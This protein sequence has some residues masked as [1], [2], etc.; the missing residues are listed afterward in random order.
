MKICLDN[1]IFSKVKNGGV[2]NYWFELIEYLEKQNQDEL[3]YFESINAIE[4]F[5]RKKL[6]LSS[7][8][9]KEVKSDSI[10]RFMPISY[11]SDEKLIFHSSY[12]RGLNGC[13]NKI[14]VTTVYDFIHSYYSSFPKKQLHNFLKFN[15]IKRS[16]GII[17]IS[18][19]TYNDLNK[20]YALKKNQKATVIHVGVSD[21]YFPIKEYT[22]KEQQFITDK[23]L[24]D[25]FILFVGGRTGYKNFDFVVSVLNDNPQLKLVIVGGGE[26][27]EEEKK[28]FSNTA[29]MRVTHFK[30][31]ENF[32]L[33]VL[34]N[35]SKALVYPS[36]YEGF[37]I[38]VVEAM[39]AGCPVIGLNNATIREVA[40]NSAVLLDTLSVSEFNAKFSNLNHSDFRSS[41]IEMGLEAS[42]NYSWKKCSRETREFYGS[43]ESLG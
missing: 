26:I 4:N 7:Q 33:N 12:Y 27:T 32:E 41:A 31:A 17:C 36:S 39:R 3:T 14:E 16:N 1:I 5:H 23:K 15:A 21:D 25:D 22:L 38:P 6:I 40:E 13:K 28:L 35:L 37:G 11:T 29:L 24:T 20:F 18:H 8:S 43:L 34:F 19:N 10:H 2:S 42:K 9:I 30:T